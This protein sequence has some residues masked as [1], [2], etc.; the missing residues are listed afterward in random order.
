MKKNLGLFIE[1]GGLGVLP[2]KVLP[3][4][5]VISCIL[6]SVSAQYGTHTFISKFRKM[7]LHFKGLVGGQNLAVQAPR[8]AI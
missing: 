6:R 5:D 3:F 2:Q 8:A 1:V 7:I 4:L